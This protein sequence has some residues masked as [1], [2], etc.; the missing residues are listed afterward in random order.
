V[1]QVAMEKQEAAD[2][3]EAREDFLHWREMNWQRLVLTAAKE[4]IDFVSNRLSL[5]PSIVRTIWLTICAAAPIMI[6]CDI[7]QSMYLPQRLAIVIRI[8]MDSLAAGDSMIN[9]HVWLEKFAEKTEVAVSEVNTILAAGATGK[10]RKIRDVSQRL[11]HELAEFIEVVYEPEWLVK[12]EGIAS[13]FSSCSP[14]S[15]ADVEEQ[16]DEAEEPTLWKINEAATEVNGT[17]AADDAEADTD[18]ATTAEADEDAELP[19]SLSRFR[20]LAKS[21]AKSMKT[22]KKVLQARTNKPLKSSSD[23]GMV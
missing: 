9:H 13:H 19:S 8:L 4:H 1:A 2:A 20:K 23:T 17:T 5:P 21:P 22:A 6:Y 11:K 3:A 7:L 16:E 15:T 14:I 10:F 18:S 12:L